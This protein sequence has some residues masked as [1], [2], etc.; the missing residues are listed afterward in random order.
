MS[1]IDLFLDLI[2]KP[3]ASLSVVIPD[4]AKVLAAQ[5]IK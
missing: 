4:R 1:M 5:P 2:Q 3:P